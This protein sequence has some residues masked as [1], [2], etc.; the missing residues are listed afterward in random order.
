MTQQRRLGY[1]VIAATVLHTMTGAQWNLGL[2][3]V[4]EARWHRLL[5]ISV[6]HF[7][8]FVITAELA[9]SSGRVNFF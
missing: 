6:Y 3:E 8:G 2:Q 5:Q 4:L 7:T 1:H 9:S